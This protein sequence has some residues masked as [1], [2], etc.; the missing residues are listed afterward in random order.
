MNKNNARI[1]FTFTLLLAAFALVACDAAAP[2][3]QAT[4][5]R[6]AAATLP[7]TLTLKQTA[8]P[9]S[10]SMAK[11]TGRSPKISINWLDCCVK[12]L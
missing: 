3:M 1:L 12:A 10:A 2:A 11:Q 9:I 7:S 6:V 4:P 5:T 8:I